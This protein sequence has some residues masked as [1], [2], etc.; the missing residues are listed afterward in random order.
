MSEFDWVDRGRGILTKRDR[1]FLQGNLDDELNDNQRY[2][3]RYQIRQRIRD[4]MFDFHIL[5]QA[6]PSRDLY[7]L[8]DETDDWIY[9][10]KRQ[11][12]R[13]E[14]PPYPEIPIL[15]RCWKDLFALFVY[16]QISTGIP[17]AESLVKWAIEGGVNKAVRRHNLQHHNTYLEADSSLDWGTGEAYKLLEYLQ[18]IGR[19]MPDKKEEAEEYLL[20]LQREEYLQSHHVTYLYQTYF[21]G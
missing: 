6:L 9:R 19:E 5:Y 21:E 7:M 1:E 11:R 13:G 2:Q 18:Q 20:N 8:W 10:S 15:G 3:K 16:S 12:E 17:E 14:A 4:A